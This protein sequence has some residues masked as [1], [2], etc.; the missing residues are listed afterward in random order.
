[1]RRLGVAGV[2]KADEVDTFSKLL[3]L[4][5]L[6]ARDSL[7]G[8]FPAKRQQAIQAAIDSLIQR[9]YLERVRRGKAEYIKLPAGRAEDAKSLAK[10]L[11]WS[12]TSHVRIVELIP[13]THEAPYHISFGE[14]E[15][16][17][18][19]SAYALC[20]RMRDECDVTC[21]V[22][23]VQ[24]R[25]SSIR[26]GNPADSKSRVAQ[27]LDRIDAAFGNR[28]FTRKEIKDKLPHKLTGNNQPTKA[29]VEYLCNA[30]YL[31]RSDYEKG[32]SMFERTEKRRPG[33]SPSK[34]KR[35]S[36]SSREETS[37]YSFYQ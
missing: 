22:I 16:R 23:D 18:H 30:K 9:K 33:T 5:R 34:D 13:R 1:M 27:F 10:R 3:K 36:E 7:V 35:S 19:L 31:R 26:L 4:G 2:D 12:D 17:G 14:H 21:Y 6:L 11:G 8:E 25:R 37:K 15:S 20:R 32:S 24:G 28:R 29:A